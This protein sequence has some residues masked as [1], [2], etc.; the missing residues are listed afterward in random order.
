MSS[1]TPQ[2]GLTNA[3]SVSASDG[4]ISWTTSNG[5]DEAKYQNIVFVL[6]LSKSRSPKPGYII[7]LLVEDAQNTKNPFRL[8]LLSADAV[9]NDLRP[10]HLRGLPDHLRPVKGK[11]DVDIV[12]STKSGVGLSLK[13]WEDVLRPLW[14]VIEEH[15]PEEP[16]RESPNILITQNADSV[17]NFARRIGGSDGSNQFRT[18]VL[19]S[20]DGG[21]VDLINSVP[22][23]ASSS[24]S[25]QRQLL[26][27]LLPLGTGNAL[28]HSLHKPLWASEGGS[29]TEDALPLVLGLRTLF[30]GVSANLPLFRASFS[31][32][33][34]IV[35]FTP[36]TT[37]ESLANDDNAKD[38]NDASKALHLTKQETQVSH[39]FGAVVAS[40]G[41]HSSIVYESDTPEYRVHGDK[42]FGMVAQEL[43]RESHPY[44][45]QVSVRYPSAAKWERF[46]GVE[47]AYVLV[48]PLS[49]LERTFTISP[50]SKPLDGK[51][52]LVHF[53][54]VGGERTLELMMKAYDGGKHVGAKWDDGHELRYE[55]VDEL[56]VTVFEDDERWRKVCIDGTIV[57]I[58]KGGELAVRKE[59]ESGFKILVDQ[60]VLPSKLE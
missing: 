46:D 55:E 8:L 33:S 12:V 6:D 40:Y 9:P 23:D 14:D 1:S 39:L 41:F 37:E 4:V 13:F 36:T 17:R 18:I 43:L 10:Y 16:S 44:S 32:G 11:Q 60:R 21:I 49:N 26:L 42:R 2:A 29:K 5:K 45:A 38:D 25:E 3:A 50:A 59:E 57:D 54:P 30:N 47:H 19:L 52:R 15:S 20:G 35:K 53:G 27:A 7:A 34:R 24:S 48:T 31:P 51:L 22:H 28:F 56:R 58:P